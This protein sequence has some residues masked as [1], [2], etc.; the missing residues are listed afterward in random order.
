MNVLLS[1]LRD[2]SKSTYALSMATLGLA[3]LGNINPE[4]VND[5]DLLSLIRCEHSSV[6]F[7]PL[8]SISVARVLSLTGNASPDVVSA[9]LSLLENEELAVIASATEALIKLGNSSIKVVST[10]LSLLSSG[11]EHLPPSLIKAF[12]E[13]AKN[14]DIILPEV[15][16]WLEEIQDKDV[17]GG[18]IDCLYSIVVE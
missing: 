13:L 12:G 1:V 16:R 15:L 2:E 11:N 9:L 3:H 14:S 18:A 10:L 6:Y 17:M 4:V 5:L 7:S 8:R